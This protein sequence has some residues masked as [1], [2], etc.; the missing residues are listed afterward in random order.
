MKAM[1][2]DLDGVMNTDSAERDE[3]GHL[4]NDKCVANL[5]KIIE[6][7]GAEI[8]ISSTWRSQGLARMVN[9]W[10]DRNL[11][12]KVIDVT[13]D[14]AQLTHYKT[15]EYYDQVERGHEI[16]EWILT[17][18]DEL[19]NYVIL[20]DGNDMLDSQEFNFVRTDPKRGITDDVVEIAIFI[21]NEYDHSTT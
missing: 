18:A 17:H 16:N 3:Y 7:T 8:V 14:C 20:D 4:F 10:M 5:A 21:L 9:M 2:L 6:A 1:F 15:L 19:E 12:G 11:P 13:P